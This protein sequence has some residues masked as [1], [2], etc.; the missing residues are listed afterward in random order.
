M[1]RTYHNELL[2]RKQIRLQRTFGA[3]QLLQA[4]WRGFSVRRCYAPVLEAKRVMR[5]QKEAMTRN[6]SATR[7][8]TR[9]RGYWARH[10][11]GPALAVLKENR[12][13]ESLIIKEEMHKKSVIMAT[14]IQGT[15]RG[16][17]A[18]KMYR[19]ILNKR[20]NE[21]RK[22]RDIRSYNAASKLQAYW[23]GHSVRQ[24][25]RPLLQELSERRTF[26]KQQEKAA[27]V[28]QALWRGHSCRVR[29]QKQRHDNQNIHNEIQQTSEDPSLSSIPRPGNKL[30]VEKRLQSALKFKMQHSKLIADLSLSDNK[31]CTSTYTCSNEDGIM[32]GSLSGED[33]PDLDKE[34]NA[35]VSLT[36]SRRQEEAVAEQSRVRMS[37]TMTRSDAEK[38][39]LEYQS[40]CFFW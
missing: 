11:Y 15:W 28:L 24:R 34:Q 31:G 30:T 38:V 25:V 10:V 20:M 35:L 14:I 33:R 8:Q 19:L 18:R 40:I 5:L 17:L 12:I 26:E 27:V 29:Y 4:F 16:Y 1:R 21:W 37:H 13:S 32:Q 36:T 39:G 7:I 23:K 22:E 3:A 6:I 2:Y 9:W